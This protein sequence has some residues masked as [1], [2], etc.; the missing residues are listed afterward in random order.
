MF[1]QSRVPT[2]SH[3]SFV[4]ELSFALFQV[5][6]FLTTVGLDSRQRSSTAESVT[7]D[8]SSPAI[9]VLNQH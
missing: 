7:S 8:A 2:S 6:G 5:E 4:L 1:F 9:V 3:L